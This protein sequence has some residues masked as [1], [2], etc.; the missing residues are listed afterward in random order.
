MDVEK[1][2]ESCIKRTTESIELEFI[3]VAVYVNFPCECELCKRGEE[4]LQ[5]RDRK[6]RRGM[7]LHIMI[8]P[9]DVPW[10]IQHAY[11]DVE[12][13]WQFSR[14]GAFRHACEQCGIPIT[15]FKEFK[16]FLMSNIIEWKKTTVK[17]YFE[18]VGVKTPD[19]DKMPE[20]QRQTARNAL[21]AQ[22]IVPVKVIP[23]DAIE[24]YELDRDEVNFK[25]KLGKKIA[26]LIAEG[27]PK[28]EI[29][30][31]VAK[32]TEEYLSKKKEKEEEEEEEEK[33]LPPVEEEE[34][35]KKAKKEEEE[36]EEEE[37]EFL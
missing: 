2:W 33:V 27:R 28:E 29:Q 31:I 34:K 8:Q 11:I 1:L 16:K 21:N 23:K 18:S 7:Q 6:G 4:A 9:L 17:D 37:E 14:K 19:V 3:G 15:P 36:E 24:L 35:A 20:R 32:L 26:P 25:V 30:E 10:E 22:V 12:K 5:E 13:T